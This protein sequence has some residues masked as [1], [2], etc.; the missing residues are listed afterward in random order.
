MMKCD[1]K[2]ILLLRKIQEMEFVAIDLNLYLN[3]HPCD[4]CA[5]NDY[6][7]AADA[8]KKLKHKYECEYGPFLNFG[9]S[10]NHDKNQ[11]Q[12]SQGP[13]PWEI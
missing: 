8:L 6:N 3:T 5:L 4:E 10:P 11:W 13:W 2:R 1:N 7:C 12:W 9:F